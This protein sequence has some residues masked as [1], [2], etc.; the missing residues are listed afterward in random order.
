[1][2]NPIPLYQEMYRQMGPQYWWPADSKMEIVIGA[3]LVQNTNWNNVDMA[4]TNLRD[5][6]DLDI[7]RILKLSV[8]RLQSLIRPS[9]FYVNK[10]RSL[11]AVL[12]WFDQFDCDFEKMSAEYGSGLRKTMLAL[13]GVGEE[14][15]DSLLVYVF[16]QPAFI[17]DKYTRTLFTYMGFRGLKTYSKLQKRII[18]PESFTYQDAQEFHGLLDEFGKKYLKD[19]QQFKDSFL[20][21]FD[22][23]LLTIN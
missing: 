14:T 18:L 6:T 4:L 15:A 21:D 2:I 10:S 12:A 8:E 22:K 16:D 9:G 13:P 20:G 1:M 19:K 23:K 17:A 11:R 5:E 7:K 3:I